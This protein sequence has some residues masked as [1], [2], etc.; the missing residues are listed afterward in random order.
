MCHSDEYILEF[1]L[2]PL[3]SGD[4]GASCKERSY[5]H[6]PQERSPMIDR[7][8]GKKREKKK[9]WFSNNFHFHKKVSFKVFSR[10]HLFN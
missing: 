8:E 7:K 6:V 9:K 10:L 5:P 3:L 1:V 2:N 4:A